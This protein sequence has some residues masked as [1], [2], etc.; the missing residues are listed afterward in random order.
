MHNTKPVIREVHRK[1]KREETTY[2]L[3]TGHDFFD[4]PDE[5]VLKTSTSSPLLDHSH[6]DDSIYA[7]VHDVSE[8]RENAPTRSHL[9]HSQELLAHVL[10]ERPP[11]RERE[12]APFLRKATKMQPV[13]LAEIQH[14]SR[15]VNSLLGS[16]EILQSLP[17]PHHSFGSTE[18][19]EFGSRESLSQPTTHVLLGSNA[20][21]LTYTIP[22]PPLP[23]E[24]Y[25]DDLRMQSFL[26]SSRELLNSPPQLTDNRPGETL[27][28]PRLTDSS[29]QGRENL[30]GPPRL[31]YSRTPGPPSVGSCSTHYQPTDAVLHQTQTQ[32]AY[33]IAPYDDPILPTRPAPPSPPKRQGKGVQNSRTQP[34]VPLP[35]PRKDETP[36]WKVSKEHSRDIPLHP[37]LSHSMD[38]LDSAIDTQESSQQLHPLPT[39]RSLNNLLDDSSLRSYG[40]PTL[41]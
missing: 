3:V 24:R 27:N 14:P 20:D 26:S 16:T 7:T 12:D 10:K 18:A 36:P 2:S 21:V 35:A 32:T 17:A 39:T 5:N 22:P 30:N 13:T 25:N 29:L 8:L 34:F 37:G 38:T 11:F 31:P 4:P 40:K 41:L 9:S 1:N 28:D 6:S 23:S 33:R 15:L 19:L